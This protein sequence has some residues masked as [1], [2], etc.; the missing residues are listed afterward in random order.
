MRRYD[1]KH[2]KWHRIEYKYVPGQSGW[3]IDICDGCGKML[4]A[5]LGE[6]STEE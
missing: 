1:C 2:E 5:A 3:Y 4:S 6:D